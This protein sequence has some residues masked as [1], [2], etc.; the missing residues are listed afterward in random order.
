MNYDVFLSH[1]SKD[2]PSVESIAHKLQNT[3]GLTCWLDKW[4]LIPGE[5]WQEALEEALDDCQTVAVFV[6]PNTISPWENEEMRSALEVRVHDKTRRVVPVLLPGA[7]DN[8]DLKLPRFLTRL[9]WVDFRAGQE[10]EDALYH[11]FCGIKGIAPGTPAGEIKPDVSKGLPPGSYIPFPRNANFVGREADLEKL[12]VLCKPNGSNII[13]S[14]AITG[15]GGIGKTQLAVEFAYSYGGN[16][17]G[18][19]WLDLRDPDALDASI[20][21]CGTFMGL[22]YDKQPE[23]VVQTIQTWQ[24][25]GP[26]LLILDNFEDITKTGRVLSRFQHP[27]LHLLITS[28]RKDF[29]KSAGL[30]FQE[31]KTFSETESLEF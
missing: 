13:I 28:R 1:N 31:L 23:Q 22:N 2:K 29:P 6:G 7:P 24:T 12:S 5:P 10:D 20:A 26:R 18:V 17:R 4:N 16:F 14:Q 21:L 27:S 30:E 19:H 15:M 9:T 11:L 3:Y 25:D 8:R